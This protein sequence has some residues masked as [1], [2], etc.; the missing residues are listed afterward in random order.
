MLRRAPER[1]RPAG[2]GAGHHRCAARHASARG[3]GAAPGRR[4]DREGLLARR[5]RS[6]A[7]DARGAA[8]LARA[9]GVR[10]AR[11]AGA[12]SPARTSTLPSRARPRRRLRADPASRSGPTSIAQPRSGSS[13]SAGRKTTPRC[14][15]TTTQLPSSYARAS[16]RTTDPLAERGRIALREAGDR[17]VALNAFP[18]RSAL[19][20]ARR[21]ALATRRSEWPELLLGLARAFHAEWLTSG[22]SSC[23][24]QHARR[25]SRAGR[26][27]VRP[28]RTRCS[29]SSG[30]TG[31]TA[32][33]ATVISI[34]RAALVAELP[35]SAGKARVLSQVARYRMLADEHE[36]AIRIGA[37]GARHGRRAR[38]RR[39]SSPRA[40]HNIGDGPSAISVTRRGSTTLERSV[41][42]A[43]AL[44]LT[45]GGAR[46][47]QPRRSFRRASATSAA[48]RRSS[49]EAV[50]LGERSRR[51][52]DAGFARDAPL[53]GNSVP[54]G[55]LG[56]GAPARGSVASSRAGGEAASD[57]LGIRRHRRAVVRLARDDVDGALED[58]REARGRS[59]RAAGDPQQRSLP[60][61]RAVRAVST[62]SWAASRRHDELAGELLD[63][64]E[65]LDALED[66]RRLRARRRAS[67]AARPSFAHVLERC[68][69]RRCGPE[70]LAPGRRRL[71][72]GRR[73]RRRRSATPIAAATPAV[74]GGE[75]RGRRSP[76]RGRGAATSR[77][78]RS[79]VRSARRAT[80]A[81]RS[82]AAPRLRDSRVAPARAR[83][84][85]RA[86]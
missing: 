49:S 26:S 35:H 41:E 6:G 16:G 69:R 8:A 5:A 86:P 72:A 4:G 71:R 65:P 21:R 75:A 83:S 13:R 42:L 64:R 79:T 52:S 55:R 1:R 77:R 84:P 28:R 58:V 78:S 20:R 51:G 59:R 7:L 11:S 43:L 61:A 10:D 33:A 23:S 29:P 53:V 17:A 39:A 27:S 2:D 46:A 48:G 76:G 24:R 63:A 34:A 67:S 80:S 25:C 85:R 50:R 36:E 14:S 9:Q 57:E 45:R 32:S 40:R 73:A 12:R 37:G 60:C 15:P 81:R 68:R 19:L 38:A 66:P 82:A 70:A 74:R 18:A 3:E 62:S 30:G 56:R 47:Q 44:R 31:G 22:G 54:R